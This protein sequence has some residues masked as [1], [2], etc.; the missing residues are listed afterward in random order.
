MTPEMQVA[1]VGVI[2]TVGG[3]VIGTVLGWVLNNLSQRGKLNCYVVEWKDEFEYNNNKGIM[4]P[5]TSKEQTQVY[6]YSF[7]IDVYNSSSSTKIMRGIEVVFAKG[8]EELRVDIPLDDSTKRASQYH[9][10]YDAVAPIN[11]PPKAVIKISLHNYFWNSEHNLDFMWNAD[12][13]YLR[14]IN[15]NNKKQKLL[16]HTEQYS[17]HFNQTTKEKKENE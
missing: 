9:T 14:Y 16:L 5:S 2:G 12:K 13:V 1:I 10:T 8:K 4:S 15:E 7:S 6:S 3:T 11:I 17:N